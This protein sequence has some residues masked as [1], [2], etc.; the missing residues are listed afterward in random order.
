[1]ADAL[2]AAQRD[3]MRER[4]TLQSQRDEYMREAMELRVRLASAATVSTAEAAA[5]AAAGEAAVRA[6][7]D[8]ATIAEQA[9]TIESL[10]AKVKA[11]ESRSAAQ[12][13]EL[14]LARRRADSRAAELDS[15]CTEF[16]ASRSRYEELME[17][18]AK[19][20]QA[21]EVAA[22]E[23][24]AAEAARI[25]AE[26]R[27]AKAEREAADSA[28]ALRA[29]LDAVHRNMEQLQAAAEAAAAV[30]DLRR[31]LAAVEAERDMAMQ[32]A[33]DVEKR[34]AAAR[35]GW[36]D[37]RE[38][39]KTQVLKAREDRFNQLGELKE[40]L[41]E[42]RD[43]ATAEAERRQELFR[44]F[45]SKIAKLKAEKDTM[46]EA[47][48]E[49]VRA[50]ASQIQVLEAELDAVKRE[51]TEATTAY[52]KDKE[53]WLDANRDAEDQIARLNSLVGEAELARINHRDELAQAVADANAA[54]ADAARAA[55][56]LASER[57]A[58]ASALSAQIEASVLEA[59]AIAA[60]RERELLAELDAVR[61]E[62]SAN[63]QRAAATAKRQLAQS[64]AAAGAA[65]AKAAAAAA[66]RSA[67]A[68]DVQQLNEQL[69]ESRDNE[70]VLQRH[71]VDAEAKLAAAA[72]AATEA[73]AHIARLELQLAR[74]KRQ[75]L[76]S[77]GSSGAMSAGVPSAR[78]R[79]LE[80]ELH[81]AKAAAEAATAD[82]TAH[83]Q[84]AERAAAE[85]NEVRTLCDEL[86]DALK[87]TRVAHA[88]AEEAAAAARAE[89]AEARA[90]AA[91]ARRAAV[92]RIPIE[93][94][95][96]DLTSVVREGHG[97][98]AQ[99]VQLRREL[100]QC[101][102][103]LRS[104]REENRALR[105]AAIL[106]TQT[107]TQTQTQAQAPTSIRQPSPPQAARL[108]MRTRVAA[109]PGGRP[110]RPATA[111]VA[112]PPRN[113]K[114]VRPPGAPMTARLG[115]RTA[116]LTGSS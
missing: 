61:A 9:E 29:E 41:R 45:E 101:Q 27:A 17:S 54:R 32:E 86:Q 59:R 112:R 55:Q 103:H 52:A 92:P 40:R 49:N 83:K 72:E 22:A 77:G 91:S 15:L 4:R 53:T 113:R 95:A 108:S 89:A 23:V 38:A 66:H 114:P 14:A 79:E 81:Q 90:A 82:A 78:L 33:K 16:A 34:Q 110:G 74:E 71:V 25:A 69:A 28:A 106:Q 37:E 65:A 107:Q 12:E 56:V 116:R 100:E 39:L 64:E 21:V 98:F 85:I 48:S 57:D 88:A 19:L 46:V 50:Q 51:L 20:S 8:A 6:A 10:R 36:D 30:P 105:A 99:F 58:A 93:G 104:A 87:T 60:A 67:Q 75:A 68:L 42:A 102:E 2:A 111:S 31:T 43:E 13:D 7:A 44:I 96:S 18:S 3:W 47:T 84:S 26:E 63:L 115:P 5:V 94:G 97:S 11:L 24:E 73:K 109:R 1:M 80:S 35:R 62:A 76:S 70:S